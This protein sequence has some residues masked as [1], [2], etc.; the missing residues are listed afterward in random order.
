MK[1]ISKN[2]LVKQLSICGQ[3]AEHK[4]EMIQ[5][6][7]DGNEDNIL[8]VLNNEEK[9]TLEKILNKLQQAWLNDH[10]EHHT[11]K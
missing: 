8:S 6:H 1:S 9:E 5:I 7:G 11:K 10:K 2:S 3:V 4:S